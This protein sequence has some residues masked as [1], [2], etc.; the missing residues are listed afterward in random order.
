MSRRFKRIDY[1]LLHTHGERVSLDESS[2]MTDTDQKINI[3]PKEAIIDELLI[4]IDVIK[5]DV[6]DFIN[7]ISFDTMAA[8]E[9]ISRLE[10]FRT[11]FRTKHYKLQHFLG[12]EKYEDFKQGYDDVIQNIKDA[13]IR[14]KDV[15]S[16]EN[17]NEKIA[18]AHQERSMLFQVESTL[19]IATELKDEWSASTM[20]K[21]SDEQLIKLNENRKESTKKLEKVTENYQE[22]LKFPATSDEM[23]KAVQDL[24]KTYRLIISQK[25]KFFKDLEIEIDQRELS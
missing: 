5:E 12:I 9:I 24:G 2:N 7:E 23:I 1:R 11:D 22:V 18:L 19:R 10:I 6:T 13:I 25:D 15:Q 14:S 20:S 16:K 8:H 21:L 3:I 4:E 17:I